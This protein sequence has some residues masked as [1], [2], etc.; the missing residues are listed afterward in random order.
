MK[1]VGNA[2]HKFYRRNAKTSRRTRIRKRFLQRGKQ[3]KL[4][5]LFAR[6]RAMI[7][8]VT[9]Q[10]IPKQRSICSSSLVNA[11]NLHPP[12]NLRTITGSGGMSSLPN[13]GVNSLTG[14]N[15]LM[16]Q[17]LTWKKLGML[18]SVFSVLEKEDLEV[19]S[20]QTYSMPEKK[21]FRIILVKSLRTSKLDTHDLQSKI[22]CV[23][24]GQ[25]EVP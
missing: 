10:N 16:I 3:R 9:G 15:L 11:N 24:A 17:I 14:S 5:F 20:A 13:V 2:Y 21:I 12:E 6:L 4:P 8:E 19:L 1:E 23:A 25:A 18:S 7:P 22:Y